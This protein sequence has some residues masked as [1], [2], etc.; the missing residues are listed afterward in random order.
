MYK[1]LLMN[2]KDQILNALCN[3][4]NIKSFVIET[5]EEWVL[6]YMYL[7]VYNKKMH[8]H[9]D[10]AIIT[11]VPDDGTTLTFGDK[12]STID[13]D[14]LMIGYGLIKSFGLLSVSISDESKII[15]KDCIERYGLSLLPDIQEMCKKLDIGLSHDFHKNT[16]LR[17]HL[18]NTKSANNQ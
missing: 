14:T 18:G 5:I 1:L 11:F 17:Y 4:D 16:I 2:A 13:Q 3:N 7:K 9:F 10:D 15:F 8:Y 12:Y 6:A